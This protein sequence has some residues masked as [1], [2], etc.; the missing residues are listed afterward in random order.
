MNQG[1]AASAYLQRVLGGPCEGM[2]LQVLTGTQAAAE[3]N[4]VHNRVSREVRQPVASATEADKAQAAQA[5]DALVENPQSN[6][7]DISNAARAE[8]ADRLMAAIGAASAVGDQPLIAMP[9][10][11]ARGLWPIAALLRLEARKANS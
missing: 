6:W 1:D 3:I 7:L 5:W 4:V 9:V 8:L 2:E 10:H 11:L